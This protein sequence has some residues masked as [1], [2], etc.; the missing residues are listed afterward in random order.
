MIG[1]LGITISLLIFLISQHK[2]L[3]KEKGDKIKVYLLS[4]LTISSSLFFILPYSPSIMTDH[5][6]R[7]FRTITEMVVLG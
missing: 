1:M 5:I 3:Q 6:N 4:A 2:S 7:F